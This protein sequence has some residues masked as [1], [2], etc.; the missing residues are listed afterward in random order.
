MKAQR[1]AA[2]VVAIAMVAGAFVVR[3]RL[4]QKEELDRRPLRVACA[5]ELGAACDRLGDRGYDL[6][7]EDAQVTA[8]RLSLVADGANP[9]TEL[10]LTAQPTADLVDA[11]RALRNAK[12]LISADAITAGPAT[13]LALVVWNDRAAVL[14]KACPSLTMRCVGEVAGRGKWSASGGR[15]EWGEVRV[16]LPDPDSTAAGLLALG[17][18]AQSWFG[19]AD[20]GSND[21]DADPA[22][23]D[24]LAGLARATPPGASLARM[25]ALGRAALDMA[26]VPRALADEL[27]RG[28]GD[29]TTLELTPKVAVAAVVVRL[30]RGRDRAGEIADVV[31]WSRESTRAGPTIAADVLEGLRLRWSA[32]SR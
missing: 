23:G 32:L 26:I 14:Q 8:R 31:R 11:L 15:A 7:V 20:I 10:W 27:T 22:F 9:E 29:V 1:L 12:P 30:P 21:F 25:L 4:D 24:W 5:T 3:S 18:G 28:I 6:V 19:R 16:A 17:A 2:L 13:S